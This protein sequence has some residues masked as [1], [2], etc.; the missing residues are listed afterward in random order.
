[1]RTAHILL[2]ATAHDVRQTLSALFDR[3][4]WADLPAGMQVTA[5]IVLA[6][7]LNNI[8]EHSYAEQGGEIDLRIHAEGDGLACVIVDRG[9]PMPCELLAA[10]PHPMDS[11]SGGLPEGGFGWY[12]IRTLARDLGYLRQGNRN[13]LSFRIPAATNQ[14]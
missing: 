13:R 10:A 7:A 3:P 11:V 9:R 14:A 12:L 8:V 5:Q 4:G 2:A 1:M 6:E